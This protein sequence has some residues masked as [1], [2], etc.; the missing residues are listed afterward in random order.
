MQQN[1]KQEISSHGEN[2]ESINQ[3]MKKLLSSGMIK[4][5]SYFVRT[6]NLFN[7]IEECEVGDSPYRFEGGDAEIVAEVRH[8][9]AVAQGEI[10]ELD[11]EDDDEGDDDSDFLPH[12]EVMELCALLE[13]TCIGYGDLDTS[14]ELPCHLHRYRAQL[15]HDDLLNC[16]QSSLDRYFTVNYVGIG[17]IQAQSKY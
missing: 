5:E 6:R 3:S 14:L 9:M 11:D 13:K 7:P 8:E 16:T 2:Y 15:Q 17:P 1:T 10:I 12:R 4:N